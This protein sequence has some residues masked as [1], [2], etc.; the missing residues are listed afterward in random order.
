LESPLIAE[1]HAMQLLKPAPFDEA[2]LNRF[3]L[4]GRTRPSPFQPE[5][6]FRVRPING[7]YR[8]PHNSCD[9]NDRRPT[10][11]K[12]PERKSKEAE[13]RVI[14]SGRPRPPSLLSSSPPI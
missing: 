8:K 6:P 9:T 13:R 11:A 12:K 7:G 14:L 2:I 4:G 1:Q 10:H 3:S 5:S